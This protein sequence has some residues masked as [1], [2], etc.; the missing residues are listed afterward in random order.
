MNN[1]LAIPEIIAKVVK[2]LGTKDQ[3]NVSCLNKT[4]RLEARRQ[5]YQNRSDIIYNFFKPD[6]ETRRTEYNVPVRPVIFIMCL[7]QK[8]VVVFLRTFNLD[9]VTELLAVRNILQKEYKRWCNRYKEL[10]KKINK[11]S[12]AME[13]LPMFSEEWERLNY[14][15]WQRTLRQDDVRCKRTIAHRDLENFDHYID[16]FREIDYENSDHGI[17]EYWG[18]EDPD[19]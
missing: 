11:C 5:L 19:A 10:N 7:A 13:G 6:L 2:H 14:L 12:Y 16:Y 8:K 3:A 9:T 1:P 17:L 18:D 15:C 4:W